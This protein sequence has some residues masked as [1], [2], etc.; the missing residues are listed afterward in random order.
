MEQAQKH[1]KLNLDT[2]QIN[3]KSN[4]PEGIVS[5]FQEMGYDLQVI[6]LAFKKAGARN[7]MAYQFQGDENKMIQELMEIIED[8]NPSEIIDVPYLYNTGE[9]WDPI[10]EIK[11]MN[12]FTNKDKK[13]KYVGLSN[14]ANICYFNCILQSFFQNPTFI[15]QILEIDVNKIQNQIKN[16]TQSRK[17]SQNSNKNGENP[18]NPNNLEIEENKEKQTNKESNEENMNSSFNNNNNLRNSRKGSSDNQ[19]SSNPIE[20]EAKKILNNKFVKMVR[21]LQEYIAQMIIGDLNHINAYE[22]TK[23]FYNDSGNRI[24]IGDQKDISEFLNYFFANIANGIQVI[25]KSLNNL[26]QEEDD[27][28]NIDENKISS[29]N[30]LHKLLYT[31]RSV[32]KTYKDSKTRQVYTQHFT[33]AQEEQ[34]FITLKQGN[35]DIYNAWD[36]YMTEE[37]KEVKFNFQGEEK[38]CHLEKKYFFPKQPEQLIFIIDR[39]KWSSLANQGFK[40]NGLFKF[41]KQIYIDRFMRENKEK[42]DGQKGIQDKREELRT[43]EEDLLNI[44]QF[45]NENSLPKQLMKMKDFLQLQV[46]HNSNFESQEI[47]PTD[48][49]NKIEEDS[50]SEIEMINQFPAKSQNRSLLYKYQNKDNLLMTIKVLDD[51]DKKSS[52]RINKLQE[53]IKQKKAEIDIFYTEFKEHPYYLQSIFVHQGGAQ[54]GHYYCYVFDFNKDI[55]IK[56]SDQD[57]QETDEQTVFNE[58]L[59]GEKKDQSAFG[60]IYIPKSLKETMEKVDLLQYYESLIHPDLKKQIIEQQEKKKKELLKQKNETMV[61]Q[62]IKLDFQRFNIIKIWQGNNKSKLTQ[63]GQQYQKPFIQKLPIVQN[64]SVYLFDSIAQGQFEIVRWYILE[65]SFRDM[66]GISMNDMS[67]Q[68][69]DS[70]LTANEKEH[71]YQKMCFIEQMHKRWTVN[72]NY[73]PWKEG[74]LSMKD[75]QYKY[76]MN[77]Y[78]Q[79]YIKA[80]NTYEIYIKLFNAILSQNVKEIFRILA[81]IDQ[82]E[83]QRQLLHVIKD[84]LR[85][86]LISQYMHQIE[87]NC[88][89][90][91]QEQVKLNEKKMQSSLQNQS[92]FSGHQVQNPQSEQ[93]N[94]IEDE[95]DSDKLPKNQQILNNLLKQTKN[96][97]Q[98]CIGYV[99][100]FSNCQQE[101]LTIL[102]QVQAWFSDIITNETQNIKELQEYCDDYMQILLETNE[103]LENYVNQKDNDSIE[104]EQEEQQSEQE[105]SLKSDSLSANQIQNIAMQKQVQKQQINGKTFMTN[106]LV[107]EITKKFKKFFLSKQYKKN[108]IQDNKIMSERIQQP[109]F[110]N[111]EQIIE[112]NVTKDHFLW[113]DNEDEDF[114][115]FEFIE[116]YI[117]ILPIIQKYTSIGKA[118]TQQ[119][120]QLTYQQRQ[121]LL[122]QDSMEN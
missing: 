87:I 27:S 7:Q 38:D 57:I 11:N 104:E 79:T 115:T 105:E 2:N 101:D 21:K 28:E 22:L 107:Q 97:I 70:N 29:Q 63:F 54:A 25:N 84:H 114:L 23:M 98:H 89:M 58:A 10:Q 53:K 117:K 15:K 95:H 49:K 106:P 93:K 92:N 26:D 36:K 71:N 13:I 102:R 110:D 46:E 64:F 67:Y 85:T 19:N 74:T 47:Q 12:R 81:F 69:D 108:W 86:I 78:V 116:K 60:L 94:K 72:N 65:I 41:E 20:N 112:K 119:E 51:F 5:W 120:N 14:N 31:N 103:F 32:Y 4:T 9:I 109:K 35:G 91:N 82:C 77:E 55:W 24:D 122:E 66:Y 62:I 37:N 39:V 34:S 80:L 73:I 52:K 96:L 50:S 61:D 33:D 100:N 76:L 118:I 6:D 3:K 90:I 30:P 68:K 43:L 16:K 75:G 83:Y 1:T 121:K 56:F 111:L 88:V 42:I 113:F 44:T 40:T 45:D 48:I 17:G 18:A 99:I 59:G 8:I